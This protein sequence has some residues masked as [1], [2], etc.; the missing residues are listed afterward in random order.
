ML[1]EKC[2]KRKKWLTWL[3]VVLQCNDKFRPFLESLKEIG[4]QIPNVLSVGAL[5]VLE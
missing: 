3:L 4:H 2:F 5:K 1:R